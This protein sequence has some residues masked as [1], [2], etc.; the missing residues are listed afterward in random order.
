M[1]SSNARIDAFYAQLEERGIQR[2]I[3]WET[4]RFD[5]GKTDT[6][7]VAFSGTPSPAIHT[8]MIIDYGEGNGFGFFPESP[9]ATI[10]GDVDLVVARPN[11]MDG[12]MADL[13]AFNRAMGVSESTQPVI[14]L[15]EVEL[16]KNLINEEH[17]ETIEA[18]DAN[19][20]VEVADGL[21]DLIYVCVQAARKFG[22][23]LAR[24]WREVQR[25]NMAKVDPAT[26]KVRRREDGKILKPEGWTAPD[27][28][29]IIEASKAGA[30]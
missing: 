2:R 14:N 13:A 24:V 7:F 5:N 15:D 21:A 10:T 20:I 27:V 19:D 8:A 6:F 29:G 23:P 9:N 30:V 28:A 26:G 3:L 12:L 22:I 1:R 17:R 18:I 11:G 16:V 4:S 25:S